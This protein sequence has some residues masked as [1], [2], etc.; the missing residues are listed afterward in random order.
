MDNHQLNE[1]EREMPSVSGLDEAEIQ[2]GRADAA[3]GK[4][5]AKP[6]VHIA[7]FR[8]IPSKLHQNLKSIAQDLGISP[9]ELARYFLEKGLARI[10]DG[11]E[12]V[13]PSFV[14]GGYTLYPDEKKAAQNK[15]RRKRSK[16]GQPPRSYYGVPREVVQAVLE[17]SQAL[18]VTQGELARYL[19]E[20]GIELYRSGELVLEPVPVQQIATLY[21]K[22]LG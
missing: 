5:A 18:G 16:K 11:E 6:K 9:G 15:P 13:A 17:Q 4:G 1:I 10:E 12:A 7:T 14:P 19:F 3:G 21:P 2:E 22:D 20:R 8:G